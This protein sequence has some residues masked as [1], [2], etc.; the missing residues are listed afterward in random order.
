MQDTAQSVPYASCNGMGYWETQD[1]DSAVSE[2]QSQTLPQTLPKMLKVG[3][4]QLRQV[5]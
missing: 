4:K 3:D 2:S 1:P 5:S